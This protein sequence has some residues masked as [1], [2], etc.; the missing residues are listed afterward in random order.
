MRKA[1]SIFMLLNL[2]FTVS[3][4]FSGVFLF[5]SA[6]CTKLK[7]FDLC[8]EKIKLMAKFSPSLRLLLTQGFL[9]YDN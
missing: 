3:H 2:S 5:V 6:E 4:T 7:N 9:H 1:F 8:G